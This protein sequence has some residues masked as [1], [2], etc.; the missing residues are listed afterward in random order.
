MSQWEY[1][2]TSRGV[3]FYGKVVRLDLSV[4]T[5]L[6]L[7][8]AILVNEILEA[9]RAFS[10]ISEPDFMVNLLGRMHVS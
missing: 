2:L 1:L 3:L 9:A 7:R 8:G 5:T 4:N 10:T 6:S